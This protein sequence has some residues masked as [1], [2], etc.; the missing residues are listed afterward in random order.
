M[1]QVGGPDCKD[2]WGRRGSRKPRIRPPSS[3][4]VWRNTSGFQEYSQC[5]LGC[6][7]R[8]SGHVSNWEQSVS[9]DWGTRQQHQHFSE[10][11]SRRSNPPMPSPR[12][13][14]LEGHAHPHSSSL[15]QPCK[16]HCK[17][18][19]RSPSACTGKVQPCRA[20]NTPRPT[21]LITSRVELQHA[22]TNIISRA[23]SA[24]PPKRQGLKDQPEAATCLQ[25][26]FWLQRPS[27]KAQGQHREFQPGASLTSHCPCRLQPRRAK[28]MDRDIASMRD[29]CVD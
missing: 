6:C 29:R 11:L 26:K 12:K 25:R 27:T 23:L 8:F 3:C 17:A 20:Y 9:T 18:G 21:S 16:S 13:V 7:N 2:S 22:T 5:K 10:L 24:T 19:Q 14:P 4:Y 28:T 15:E 1:S